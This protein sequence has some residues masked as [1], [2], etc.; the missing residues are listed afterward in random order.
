MKA[1]L[2]HTEDA[3]V[4]CYT[5]EYNKSTYYVT[6]INYLDKDAMEVVRDSNGNYVNDFDICFEILELVYEE[7]ENEYQEKLKT[8]KLSCRG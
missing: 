5:V 1:Q 4:R 3:E 7:D 8:I 2:I 6:S